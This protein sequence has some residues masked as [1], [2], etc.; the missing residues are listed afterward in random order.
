MLNK[1]FINWRTRFYIYLKKKLFMALGDHYVCNSCDYEWRTKKD[2]GEPSICPKCKDSDI[3]TY[4]EKGNIEEKKIK[5]YNEKQIKFKELVF[6]GLSNQE[7]S[8]EMNLSIDY[9]NFLYNELKKE[10]KDKKKI[11]KQEHERNKKAIKEK[12]YKER[13][14]EKALKE[15]ERLF[16]V[17]ILCWCISFLSFFFFFSVYFIIKYYK[18]KQEIEKQLRIV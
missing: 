3:I 2:V 7:I 4:L 13:T 12:E 18:N 8:K 5:V 15:N 1:Y 6:N 14:L 11:L 17:A 16:K 10:E 9:V